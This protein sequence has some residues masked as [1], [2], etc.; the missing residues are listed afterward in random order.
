[1]TNMTSY[2][3]TSSVN[4]LYHTWFWPGT[5]WADAKVPPVARLPATFRA[6]RTRV[7]SRTE[8]LPHCT[9]TGQPAQKSYRTGTGR[10]PIPRPLTW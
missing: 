8:F 10:Q 2:G 9:A 5:K 7:R 3:A 1:M 6:A 4:E